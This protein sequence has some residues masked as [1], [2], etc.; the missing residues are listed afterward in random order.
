MVPAPNGCPDPSKRI[1]CEFLRAF[2]HYYVCLDNKV[3][4]LIIHKETG[5]KNLQCPKCQSN[6][7]IR[8]PDD[9]QPP[10]RLSGAKPPSSFRSIPTTRYCCA[11]CGYCETWVDDV[12]DLQKVLKKFGF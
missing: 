10:S 1:I 5:M 7:I 4:D 8:F 11:N 6:E 12:K 9:I 2:P 3:P